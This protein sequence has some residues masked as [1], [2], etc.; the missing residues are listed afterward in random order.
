MQE[1]RLKSPAMVGNGQPRA[2]TYGEKKQYQ[3]Q[4]QV[5][6]HHPVHIEGTMYSDKTCGDELTKEEADTPSQHVSI[7]DNADDYSFDSD[8][9]VRTLTSLLEDMS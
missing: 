3:T 7:L 1:N 8:E 6:Q 4:R 2:A 5:V 9:E